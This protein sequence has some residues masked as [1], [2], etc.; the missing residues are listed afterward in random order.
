MRITQNTE[1]YI[2]K[3]ETYD[4]KCMELNYISI[5]YLQK[6]NMRHYFIPTGYDSLL[7]GAKGIALD[8]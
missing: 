5:K 4:F 3:G 1:L 8:E 7:D 2:F 6:I